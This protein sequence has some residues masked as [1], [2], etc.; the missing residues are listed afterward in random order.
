VRLDEEAPVRAIAGIVIAA[1]V[2]V[3]LG[4][5]A[6]VAIVQANAP[7]KSVEATFKNKNFEE[8]RK[9]VEYGQR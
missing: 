7:D 9:V 8:R 6:T 5:G 2:G 3:A 4:V 1:V